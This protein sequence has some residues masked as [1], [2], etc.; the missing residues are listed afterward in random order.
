MATPDLDQD[1][2]TRHAFDAV[3]RLSVVVLVLWTIASTP[4]G[5]ETAILAMARRRLRPQS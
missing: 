1:S 5:P 3:I 2:M 4:S